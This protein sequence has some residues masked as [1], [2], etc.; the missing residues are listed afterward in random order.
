MRSSSIP[1]SGVSS[2]PRLTRIAASLDTGSPASRAMTWYGRD[3][4]GHDRTDCHARHQIDPR[5]PAAFDA[6][7][8]R[9]G[10]APLS[11]SLLAI[12]ETAPRGDPGLRAGAGTAQCGVEGNRRR[13]EGEGRGARSEADGG[14]R[15]AQDHDAASSSWPRRR[16]TRS[17][18]RNW[19]RS[20]TCRSTKCPTAS[21]STAMC[22]VTSSARRAITALRRSRMTI[23][24]ARSA[25]W[26]SRRRRN[27]PARVLSC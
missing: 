6:G 10:L 22:S 26:I 25:T 19:P 9:R 12:D 1:R 2:M 15:R 4:R 16:P 13:Q 8:K 14:S 20:R 17:S 27:C 21:T 23:S 11:P 18:P 7:L 5:Q 24:A 3:K